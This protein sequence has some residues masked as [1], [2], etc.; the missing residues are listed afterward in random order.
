MPFYPVFYPV[1]D[2]LVLKFPPAGLTNSNR[3]IYRFKPVSS[4]CALTG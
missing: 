3:K 1:F 4:V 2:P